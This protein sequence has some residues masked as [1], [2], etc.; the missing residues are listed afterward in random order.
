M[1]FRGG[2]VGLDRSPSQTGLLFP[3]MSQRNP[4]KRILGAVFSKKHKMQISS[5]QQP[6]AIGPIPPPVI[7]VA[8]PTAVS[9]TGSAVDPTPPNIPETGVAL[10]QVVP[11]ATAASVPVEEDQSPSTARRPSPTPE[12]ASS[13]TRPNPSLPKEKVTVSR[14]EYLDGAINAL[15]VGQAIGEAIPLAGGALKAV[16]V[17]FGVALEAWRVSNCSDCVAR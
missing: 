12:P 9:P 13:A 3:T 5:I 4:L 2:L 7:M 8:P 10:S 14:R 6:P 1:S 11:Q 15:K 16:C 17:G